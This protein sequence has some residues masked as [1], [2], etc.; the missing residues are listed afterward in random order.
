MKTKTI[1]TF[2]YSAEQ[3]QRVLMLE[4]D[5]IPTFINGK[6]YT[7]VITTGYGKSNY[8]DAIIVAELPTSD[9]KLLSDLDITF[10]QP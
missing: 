5:T 7:E 4:P 9:P 3:K 1:A 2:Y 10:Y 6:E 8:S